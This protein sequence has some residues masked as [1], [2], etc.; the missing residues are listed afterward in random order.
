MSLQFPNSR[1]RGQASRWLLLG[2]SLALVL[3]AWALAPGKAGAAVDPLPGPDHP[4][5]YDDFSGGGVFT[6]DWMNWWNQDGGVGL[7]SRTTDGSREVGV[8]AQEPDSNKSWSKFQ[9]WNETVDLSGYRYLNFTMKNTLNPDTLIRIVINDTNRN[10][11]L[12]GGWVPVADTWTLSQFDLDALTPAISKKKVKFEIWLRQ[13]DGEPGEVRIDDIIAT[14]DDSG[15]APTLTQT[16]VTANATGSYNQNTQFT[17]RATYTD[18]DNEA[19]FAMQVVIDDTAYPMQPTDHGDHTYTDGKDYLYTTKLAP[20]SH[21][22]YFRTTDTTS[23]MV[24]TTV[25]TGL[26]VT[27]ASQLIDVVVSQAGYSAGDYKSAKVTATEPLGDLAFEVHDGSGTV[28][29]DTLVSEG[30]VW[31]KHVYTADFSAVQATGETFTVRTN[32]ISSFPFPIAANV[33]DRYKDEMT[34]FYRIQRASVATSDAYPDGYSTVAPSDKVY[35]PAGH[36]DDALSADGTQQ[37]DLTGGWY[38]AGDYGKYG[39]NQW[40]GAQIALAYV[41]HAD[42]DSV[43]YDN[44][45]NGIPDLIDEAIFGSDYVVKFADQLGGAMY[46]VPKRGSFVHP[47]KTT[48]NIPG[49]SDDR[50]LNGYGIGGSAKAAGTLAATARAIHTAI[51]EG[52][53]DAS[54]VAALTAAAAD[55]E[56]AAEVFYNYVLGHLSDPIGSYST[57]G[58]IDNSMLLADVELYLLTGDPAYKTAATDKINALVFEDLASTNYWDMRPMSMAE[59]YPAADSATQAHIQDLLK[60][61]LDYFMSLAD[62][63]PYGVLNQFKNFGVNEPHASYLGDAM[64]YYE[65]FGDP[66]ALR[67]VQQG[68]YWIFGE[69]PWN[70]SWVSGIGADHVDY[71]HTRLDEQANSASAT[72]I[73][74]PGAMVSGPNMKNP[75]DRKSVSPW[76]ED[77][78]VYSDDTNQWRYNEYSVSIQAGLLYTVV[79]LGATDTSGSPAGS[80]P[81]ELPVLSPIIGDYVRGEVTVFAG[82]ANG[83]DSVTYKSGSSYVPMTVSGSVYAATIDESGSAPYANK[84]ID[85][86]GLDAQGNATY[87][88]THYT[89]AAPLPDP[90]T[91]LLYDDFDG[92]GL[93]G[94]TGGNNQWVNWYSQNGGTATFARVTEDGR[95][96]GLFTQTPS[97]ASS[98]ARFQPWHDFVDLSGY[99]YLNLTMKNPGYDDLRMRVELSDG[100]RT[101]NATGGYVSVP[102]TWQDLQIDLDSFA[103][104]TDKST[105]RIYIWLSQSTAQYGELFIDEIFASNEASGS[106]P[107]LTGG[108]VNEST[109]DTETDFTFNVTYTDAD[110]EAPF[111]VE[112]LLDGVVHPMQ[113]V[114]P[115]DTTY[116]DGKDYTYTTKLPAGIHSY[117]FHTSDTTSDAV[118]TAVQS[119][120]AVGPIAPP[121]VLPLLT[122][123]FEDGTADGWTAG[124]G[125]WTVTD[126]VYAGQAGSGQSLAVAGDA[127]W[128]DYELEAKV[129]VTNNTNGNKDAGLV[130]RYADA[131]NFYVLFLK[132][133]DRSGRKM[134]LVKYVDG[135]KTT[136]DYANPSVAA[137]TYYTYRI[138]ADGDSLEVYQD[139]VLQLSATDSA[140]AAGKIGARVYASTL[141]LFDDFVVTP[142]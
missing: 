88:S 79:A 41:R 59:F 19:P 95:E 89:I 39:G 55:Y 119:G 29:T 72:G 1:R 43:K 124:S 9:P 56:D 94:A 45:D 13:T 83:L 128:T 52:D 27:E 112:L 139:D 121:P 3:Q 16:G 49:T 20:G 125:T 114:D 74:I 37:L 140:H 10:Y 12:T 15:S 2:L 99:R 85:V 135:V 142:L 78:S 6:Q 130:F 116:S 90:S 28:L 44:D 118:S 35:H 107:T 76:Y 104:L 69:N 97:S 58:G 61:Q 50:Q 32:G 117:Y 126:G 129:N 141:A 24:S 133:D 82:P 81:Q 102:D 22:Y 8:F 109:G 75:K 131:D 21:D 34:A 18:A 66:A 98:R 63:T 111:A 113:P 136:L 46:N 5:V 123:D 100:S 68:T 80:M 31:D 105:M 30:V 91:P 7:F 134:E 106:A 38:D 60:Q 36:L 87:S 73:I 120:P 47:H 122:E 115:G 48:D 17:F 11:T 86:R 57:R 54:E 84:R 92:G 65:L 108:G 127:G 33:W 14:T 93:W 70:I 26:V 137:E 51:A 138:V 110:D 132:N 71:L 77:R 53:I 23:S 42:A 64:R 67:A 96:A 40:V 62:D 25:Q 4:L 101:Y 103:N